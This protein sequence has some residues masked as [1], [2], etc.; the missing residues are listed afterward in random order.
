MEAWRNTCALL[1]SATFWM[2]E[3]LSVGDVNLN[4]LPAGALLLTLVI[5]TSWRGYFAA[6]VADR[7]GALSLIAALS[8][9]AILALL[10]ATYALEPFRVF[11]VAYG[12]F[13]GVLILAYALSVSDPQRVGRRLT[14]VLIWGATLS[15]ALVLVAYFLPPLGRALFKGGDRTAALFKH[16]NQFGIALSTCLPAIIAAAFVA[17]RRKLM[18]SLAQV[19]LILMGLILSGSKTNIIL[20]AGSCGIM[21]MLI[22]HHRGILVR[23]PHMAILVVGLAI[24][25][26]IGGFFAL[27]EF[28]PRSKRLITAFAEGGSIQSTEA[29]A[30]LWKLS[31]E[32]GNA[33]PL[34]GVGAGQRLS[35]RLYT[36][37]HNVELDYFRTLGFPGLFAILTVIILI[38]ST[39]WRTLASSFRISPNGPPK[40]IL[41]LGYAF[42][43]INYILANQLSDSF[44]PSTV[45]LL[46]LCAGLLL[47]Y[48]RYDN[49]GRRV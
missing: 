27:E 16:S 36:H 10:S 17:D 15:C 45:P 26:G 40:D 49:Q 3:L 30:H 20:A 7:F 14:Q 2:P 47:M 28:N 5:G 25:I 35:N 32:D 41:A 44:G 11:R 18:V 1:L 34:T 22:L 9:I 39:A 4:I 23:S 38:M 19:L 48:R 13:L 24:A 6:P 21:V 12:Q 43:A 8:V 46:W 29:R 31:L 37:S 33:N 42:G